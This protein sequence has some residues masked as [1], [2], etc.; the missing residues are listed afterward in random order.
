MRRS[1]SIAAISIIAAGIIAFGSGCS[2]KPADFTVTSAKP[3]LTLVDTGAKGPSIGDYEVFS[4]AVTK[5]GT[6]FGVLYGMKLEVALPPAPGAPEGLGRFQ[7]QLTF[8]L[9]DGTICVAGV[10]YYTM[11]GSIPQTLKEGELRAIVG[12]TGAYAGARGTL[13]TTQHLDGTRTQELTFLP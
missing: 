3:D 1:A 6:P 13:R 9:P 8:D 12:G 5:D 2:S 10:Q 7:N 11:D 4:S